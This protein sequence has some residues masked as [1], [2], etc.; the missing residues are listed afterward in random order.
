MIGAIDAG[1]ALKQAVVLDDTP[2]VQFLEP[3]SIK[4]SQQHIVYHKDIHFP[5][6]EGVAFFL[7]RFFC[8]TNSGKHQRCA[9]RPPSLKLFING[10]GLTAGIRHYHGAD[11]TIT[12]E[13]ARAYEVFLYIIHQ[14]LHIVF[15][16]SQI[17]LFD[18]PLLNLI[19][20][21]VQY[22]I[23]LEFVFCLDAFTDKTQ[24]VAI[25]NGLIVII[26]VNIIAK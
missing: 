5:P 19:I 11:G 13:Q 16:T 1:Q 12:Q 3:G 9:E 21:L 24:S 17:F 10:L 7:E 26:L 15:M 22:G 20:Q 2:Q 18:K 8:L 23:E 6:L 14:R 25:S 4:A